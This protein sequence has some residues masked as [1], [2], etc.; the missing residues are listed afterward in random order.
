MI[1]ACPNIIGVKEASGDLIQ[2][3]DLIQTRPRG[4]LVLSGDDSLTRDVISLG[5]DGVV[6]VA[7][8]A[9]PRAITE[10]VGVCFKNGDNAKSQQSIFTPL[11]AHLFMQSNP[12]PLKTYLA[13]Q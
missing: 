11:F 9:F 13:D 8:N 5:G 4:F 1:E 6:S 2:I 12:L 10:Y 3:T 7:S